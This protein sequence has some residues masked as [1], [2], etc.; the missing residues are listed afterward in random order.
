MEAHLAGLDLNVF[1]F[2][3]FVCRRVFQQDWVP[4]EEHAVID[5][6]AGHPI[7]YRA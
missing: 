6:E 7:V 2:K 4:L 1:A 3:V 5:S